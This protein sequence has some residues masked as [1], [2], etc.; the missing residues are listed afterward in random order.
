V[1]FGRRSG[2]IVVA[3]SLT[4]ARDAADVVRLDI[5]VLQP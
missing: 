3:A 2:G 4:E 1:R 5:E